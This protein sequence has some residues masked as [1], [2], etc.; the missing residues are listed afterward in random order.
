MSAASKRTCFYS[1]IDGLIRPHEWALVITPLGNMVEPFWPFESQM[2]FVGKK[3]RDDDWT[4]EFQRVDE[5]VQVDDNVLP[6]MLSGGN[7][8]LHGGSHWP[9]DGR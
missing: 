9:R 5:F 7:H 3:P 4:N 1:V 8:V 2:H 6:K